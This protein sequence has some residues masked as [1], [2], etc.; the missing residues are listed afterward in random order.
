MTNFRSQGDRLLGSTN[1]TRMTRRA[2]VLALLLVLA[3]PLAATARE[4]SATLVGPK[5]PPQHLDV[6]LTARGNGDRLTRKAPLALRPTGQPDEHSTTVFVDPSKRFQRIE[7][8]GGA[9]TDASAETFAKLSPARQ[10]EI[11]RAYYDRDQGI[12]YSLGRTHINACD[13]SS[14]SYVYDDVP[15]DLTL[16]HFSI[17]HDMQYRIPFIRRVLEMRPDLKIF[18]S[19]WSPP[20]WMKSNHDVLHGGHLLATCRDAWAHYYVKFIQAYAAA[21]IPMW[22]LT[23]QNEPMAAQTWESCIYT[24]DEERDFVRDFLG[25]ALRAAHLDHVKLMIWDH[26]RGLVYQR[27]STV[28]E[29]DEAAQYV[30]GT[31]YHWYVGDSDENLQ[32]VHDAFPD[33]HIL[34]TEGCNYPFSWNTIDDWKWGENYGRSM[35]EDFNHWSEGWTDWNVLLDER[36]GPNH[37]G[38]YCFAP[39]IA[40]TRHDTLHYMNAYYYIGHF[41]KFVQPGAQRI[42]CTSTQEDIRATAFL[43]RTEAD[44][45]LVT[46]IMN[47]TDAARPIRWQLGGSGAD[48]TMPPHSIATL[49]LAAR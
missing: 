46:V 38:N 10:T 16:S 34:F 28:L 7:G 30:W 18:A 21:G 20:A 11:L 8:I 3:C 32:R 19:P 4:P 1:A 12:G 25:P 42:A 5:Q 27:A 48:L 23:V 6:W 43:E 2:I 35:I 45:R 13:F 9:L 29:D 14:D 44:G 22:G 37:V 47:G 17:Q 15:N 31:A 40:D 24:A 49:V 39:I 33:K 41:S 26:N 36:G